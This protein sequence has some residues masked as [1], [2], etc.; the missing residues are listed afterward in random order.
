MKSFCLKSYKHINP[1]LWK[2]R[3]R[4]T[5]FDLARS[6]IFVNKPVNCADK[7]TA[8]NNVSQRHRNEI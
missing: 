7:E 1:V 4:E 3:L 2:L 8:A 6:L 5:F